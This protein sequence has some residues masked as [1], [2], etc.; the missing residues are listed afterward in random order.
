MSHVLAV[1]NPPRKRQGGEQKG[2][3]ETHGHR[4]TL[5]DLRVLLR[6]GCRACFEEGLVDLGGRCRRWRVP[7]CLK[8]LGIG[9]RKESAT[10]KVMG[11]NLPMTLKRASLLIFLIEV[12]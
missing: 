5:A 8:D 12:A 4:R 3:E 10:L 11:T 1:P 6:G 9:N 7:A 2:G